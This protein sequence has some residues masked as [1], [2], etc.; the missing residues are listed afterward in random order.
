MMTPIKDWFQ[1]LAKPL[2]LIALTALMVGCATAPMTGRKQLT[3]IPESEL[4]AMSQQQY[5]SFLQGEKV[6][7]NS[8]Q[9]SQVEKVGRRIAA[10]TEKFVADNGLYMTF[11]WEFNVVESEEVN[12]WCMPGGKIVFYTGILPICQDDAGIAIVMGH[13]VAH[14]LARHGNERMSQGLLQQLGMVALAE[15][16]K[17]Y[18][19]E[20]QALW[21]TAFGAG[22]S[23]GVML[24]FSRMQELEADQIGLTL[25]AMAGF[26]PREAVPFWKRMQQTG[27]TR[28]PEFLSTHPSSNRRIQDLEMHMPVAMEHYRRVTG[29]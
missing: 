28:P 16:T 13:E 11:N 4:V 1:K 19:K 17:Q 20:T 29:N 24:P 5:N 21:M 14:A 26:D 9:V 12:A 7:K 25:T 8:R 23:V 22:T 2:V 3:L 6:Q 15:A 27:G 10:A 18:S